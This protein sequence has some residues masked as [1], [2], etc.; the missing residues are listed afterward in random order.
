MSIGEV[1]E[2]ILEVLFPSR[3]V[4]L[5]CGDER[6]CNQPFL[7]DEC[8]ALLHSENVQVIRPEWQT[9]GLERV[10]F[11]YYYGRPIRGLIRSFKFHGIRVLARIFAPVM[12]ELAGELELKEIDCLV[13]VPL[14]PARERERGY[15]QAKLLADALS[16]Q[17]GIP[18]RTDLLKRIRKTRQQARLSH[19]QRGKNT[20]GAFLTEQNLNGMRILL[21]DDVITT[22]S[23]V[24]SC[25][26]ALRAAGAA[27]VEAISIAG[28]RRCHSHSTHQY[29]PLKPG[30]KL[31][32]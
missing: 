1:L 3:A 7:C 25:A 21:V 12:A 31:L 14:H 11:V 2:F 5:G 15:N 22:G 23:T 19:S 27:H 6:G 20:R 17:I 29:R 4:C 10:S 9:R 26:E 18:V 16:V 13:P 24:S 8:I 28:T 32:G 30:R